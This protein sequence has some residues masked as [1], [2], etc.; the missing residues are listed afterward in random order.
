MRHPLRRLFR[1]IPNGIP[2]LVIVFGL[3]GYL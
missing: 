1:A 2:C 3:I